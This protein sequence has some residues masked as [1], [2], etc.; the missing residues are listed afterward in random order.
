MKIKQKNK[1]DPEIETVKYLELNDQNK[2]I[3]LKTT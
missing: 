1:H 2:K 3:N